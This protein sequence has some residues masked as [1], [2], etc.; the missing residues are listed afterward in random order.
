[1]ITKRN[2]KGGVKR[3]NARSVAYEN[4]PV[5]RVNYGAKSQAVSMHVLRVKII[6]VLTLVFYGQFKRPPEIASVCHIIRS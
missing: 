4:I 3:Y 5:F 6:L 2:V 1:M